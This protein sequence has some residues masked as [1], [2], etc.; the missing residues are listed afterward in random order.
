MKQPNNQ[1]LESHKN[2]VLK[3]YFIAV[4]VYFIGFVMF[5]WVETCCY[6]TKNI[7]FL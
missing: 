7:L 2:F 1:T 4:F 3:I 6:F 5:D